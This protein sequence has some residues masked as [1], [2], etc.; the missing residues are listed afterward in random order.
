VTRRAV[1]RAGAVLLGVV[2]PAFAWAK[3]AAPAD[4]PPVVIGDVRIEALHWGRAEGLPHNGGYIAAFDSASGRKLW[5]LKVYGVA[6]QRGRETDVQDVF[7]R[8]MTETAPG[9]LLII[10]E[11][12]RRYRVD[13]KARTVTRRLKSHAD[14]YY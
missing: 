11:K 2:L 1:L 7:I 5:K 8:S 13:V 6:Y 9:Q 12:G 10:D 4:V 14:T 3:R